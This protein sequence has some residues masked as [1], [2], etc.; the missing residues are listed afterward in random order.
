MH[1]FYPVNTVEYFC[2]AHLI[3]RISEEK[4]TKATFAV[5]ELLSAIM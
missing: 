3:L 4:A 2:T 1:R 5:Q